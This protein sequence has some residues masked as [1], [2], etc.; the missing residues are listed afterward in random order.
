MTGETSQGQKQF[1]NRVFDEFLNVLPRGIKVNQLTTFNFE[2]YINHRRGQL[3]KQT[4]EPLKPQ[5]INKELYAISGGLKMAPKFFAELE[6]WRRPPISFLPEEDSSRRL[7]L[8]MEEFYLLLDE[9][10]KE[11]TGRQTLRAKQHQYHLADDLEFRLETGLRRKEVARLQFKQYNQKE[12]ILENV[13]RWKTKTTTKVFPLSQKAIELIELRRKT[14]AG[15]PFI[16]TTDGE[17]VESYYRTLK[18]VC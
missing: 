14:Q 11:K 2:S 5:T 15:S 13:R 8:K 18:T 3:G 4:K 1:A 17:P 12:G 7:N 10:R 6:N 9:L 16:F